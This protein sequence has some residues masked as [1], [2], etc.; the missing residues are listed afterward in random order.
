MKKGK[1]HRTTATK[2]ISQG[3]SNLEISSFLSDFKWDIINDVA[4]HLNIMT[5]K[6]KH[7]EVESQ[8][9]EYFPHCHK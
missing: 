3:I 1:G 5:T 6:K 4:T 9:V 8:L 7:A 2:G